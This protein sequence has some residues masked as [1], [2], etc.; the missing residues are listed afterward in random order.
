MLAISFGN[1]RLPARS[2]IGVRSLPL[3]FAV[4]VEVVVEI[5][6]AAP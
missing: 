3:G 1:E 6:A 2:V 4:E 5:A